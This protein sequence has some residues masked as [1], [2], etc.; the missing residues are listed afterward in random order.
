[1]TVRTVEE[2]TVIIADTAIVTYIPAPVKAP[3]AKPTPLPADD[4]EAAIAD[5]TSGAPFAIARNVTP[6][7]YSETPSS[8][9]I[10][11]REGARNPPAVD[12]K[13]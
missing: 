9:E 6:A 13:R 11:S 8:K 12:P 7:S 10:V 3:T 4:P 2:S 5:M 1:M